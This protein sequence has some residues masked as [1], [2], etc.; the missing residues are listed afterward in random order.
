MSLLLSMVSD[1]LCVCVRCWKRRKDW[2]PAQSVG[3][4]LPW[5]GD[6]MRKSLFWHS[7]QIQVGIN[8]Q[9]RKEGVWTGWLYLTQKEHKQS[10][11]E[12]NRLDGTCYKETLS[13]AGTQP[14]ARLPVFRK[15]QFTLF[16]FSFCF[17]HIWTV[18][19]KSEWEA[20]SAKA[21]WFPSVLSYSCCC[22][23]DIFKQCS[24]IT[25]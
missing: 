12:S 23:G 1:E 15:S 20:R 14:E 5:L 25:W 19:M 17:N 4:F 7:S 22:C 2:A 9:N 13:C 6:W 16:F 8:E 18:Q 11:S 3:I 21:A 24:Q 10:I